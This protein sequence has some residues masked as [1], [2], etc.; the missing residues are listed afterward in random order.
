MRQGF[1][2]GSNVDPIKQMT[3]LITAQRTYEMG[4]KALKAADEMMQT[5]NQI[6]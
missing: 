1:L 4:A 3:D 5:A 2:E 6:R